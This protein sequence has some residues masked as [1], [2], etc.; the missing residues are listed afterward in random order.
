MKRIR[1]A[2][3]AFVAIGV[4]VEGAQ[5]DTTCTGTGVELQVLGSG[6]PELQDKR[7]SSSYVV[8][9][10]GKARVLIDAGG[11]S[12]LR[13]GESGA[14]M[15]DLEV[16]LLSHLHVDHTGD[17]PALFMSSYFGE[18][19]KALPLFGPLG[20]AYF[21][22]TTVFIADLFDPAR[23]AYRY[24]GSYLKGEDDGYRLQPHDVQLS[25]HE[26]RRLSANDGIV[27]S[28]TTVIHGS[29]PALAW[30]I[31]LDHRSLVF[32]GDGNGDNGNLQKLARGADLLV[33]HNAIPEG[34][35]CHLPSS[36]SS[37]RP[38]MRTAS[39][40]PTACFGPWGTRR[41]RSAS[42]AKAMPARWPSPTIWIAFAE[43]APG[44]EDQP[45][46]GAR[47]PGNGVTNIEEIR[48][49]D[50]VFTKTPLHLMGTVDGVLPAG[51]TVNKSGVT[52]MQAPGEALAMRSSLVCGSRIQVPF[53]AASNASSDSLYP[54]TELPPD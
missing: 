32:S 33:I 5:A 41:K 6:G 2:A 50:G 30:R 1:T 38:R 36:V 43:S 3:A 34:T 42:S 11:G 37:P 17:L 24:L 28:A 20:N 47:Q 23:G 45:P 35:T 13:F 27:L 51:P 19:K 40:C 12:A 16:M 9:R 46:D 44:A 14:Q 39:C 21:P 18:R 53:H 10:D 8:W 26:I 49:P 52:S 22:A 54:H 48:Q 15:E 31:D 29:V 7:A 25:A 4:L